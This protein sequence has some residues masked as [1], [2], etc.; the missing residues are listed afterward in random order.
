MSPVTVGLLG[1]TGT[2]GGALFKS[3]YEA[4]KKGDVKLVVLHRS[5]SD[6]S[7]L[8]SDVDKRV[9]D[10]EESKVDAIKDATKDF[11]VVISAVGSAGLKSQIYLVQALAGSS[12]LK[13]FFPSDFGA[14]WNEKERAVPALSVFGIKEEVVAKAKELKVPVT[15]V[16][17][18]LF[19]KFFFAYKALGSDVKSNKVQYFRKS[20]D[21]KIHITSLAYLGHAVTQLITT[22]SSLSELGNTQ[23]H[24]YDLTPTGNEIA[25]AF[26]KINGS[27]P[28]KYELKEEEYEERLKALPGAITAAIFR[29]WGEDDWGDLPKTEVE[30]WKEE[31]FEDVAKAWAKNA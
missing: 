29:K 22:P 28:Q 6:T 20:L 11:E 12:S 25:S 14:V 31:K 19:D 18:G 27:A 21:N 10:L 15:E 4:H 17:V 26:E 24:L 13:T 2:V 1:P 30:G 23:P 3:L 7:K 16:K 5:G 8:P 9:V